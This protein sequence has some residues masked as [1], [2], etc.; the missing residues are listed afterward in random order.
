MAKATLEEEVGT[1]RLKPRPFKAT[2]LR[3][4][5]E[6]MSEAQNDEWEE[7]DERAG[8]EG[9]EQAHDKRAVRRAR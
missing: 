3:M 4:T 7:N 1:A 9:R 8:R 5:S 6:M 2:K